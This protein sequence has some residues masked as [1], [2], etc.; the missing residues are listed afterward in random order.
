MVKRVVAARELKKGHMLAA[1]D[2]AFRIPV[3]AKITSHT[4]RPFEAEQIVGHALK[5]DIGFEEPITRVDL[6]I[7]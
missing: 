5:R 6:G 3:G 1:E 2:L 7:N 4:L